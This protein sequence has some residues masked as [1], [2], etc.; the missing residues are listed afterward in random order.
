MS[1]PLTNAQPPPT[2]KD[3]LLTPGMLVKP[4]YRD[5]E[6]NLQVFLALYDTRHDM[7]GERCA[8]SDQD[9]AKYCNA[10]RSFEPFLKQDK[11]FSQEEDRVM[12]TLAGFDSKY[13]FEVAH[14]LLLSEKFEKEDLDRTTSILQNNIIK[15]RLLKHFD[16][17]KDQVKD[18]LTRFYK[19]NVGLH[20]DCIKLYFYDDKLDNEV[21]TETKEGQTPSSKIVGSH[22]NMY[23]FNSI[24]AY[25]DEASKDKDN[26]VIVQFKSDDPIKL[27]ADNQVPNLFM[28]GD[29]KMNISFNSAYPNGQEKLDSNTITITMAYTKDTD[30]TPTTEECTFT[31]DALQRQG[32]KLSVANLCNFLSV[33]G[34]VLDRKADISKAFNADIS[35][36]FNLIDSTDVLVKFGNFIIKFGG[37]IHHFANFVYNLKRSLDYS[38]ILLVKHF[39]NN[40]VDAL[41]QNDL[42]PITLKSASTAHTLITYD[43]LC[44]MKALMQNTPVIFQ[45]KRGA[46][47]ELFINRGNVQFQLDDLTILKNMAA[48]MNTILKT[49]KSTKILDIDKITDTS[50]IIKQLQNAHLEYM[51]LY[52]EFVPRMPINNELD[53]GISRINASVNIIAK[54]QI[55][56][57][58]DLTMK[59]IFDTIKDY[60]GYSEYAVIHSLFGRSNSLLNTLINNDLTK[61]RETSEKL[62]LLSE[63]VN[64]CVIV[65]HRQ[66]QESMSKLFDTFGMPYRQKHSEIPLNNV[67]MSALVALFKT[68]LIQVDK[69]TEHIENYLNGANIG[70]TTNAQTVISSIQQ[71]GF[72][73][74]QLYKWFD[75]PSN[76]RLSR[77]IIA[78][79]YAPASTDPKAKR[80]ANALRKALDNMATLKTEI[81]DGRPVQHITK[82]INAISKSFNQINSIRKSLQTLGTN[83]SKKN[84]VP[85][86]ALQSITVRVLSTLISEC[87][88]RL[89]HEEAIAESGIQKISN[90]SFL[91]RKLKEILSDDATYT[92]LLK[93]VYEKM[94]MDSYASVCYD[95]ISFLKSYD[96]GIQPYF[97]YEHENSKVNVYNNLKTISLG[98]INILELAVNSRVIYDIDKPNNPKNS[99]NKRQR[100]EPTTIPGSSKWP[101]SG[102]GKDDD[103]VG[104]QESV[105]F[106]GSFENAELH[107]QNLP[108]IIIDKLQIIIYKLQNDDEKKIETICSY[109]DTYIAD[110]EEELVYDD[111]VNL[112][113]CVL[114][115]AFAHFANHEVIQDVLP[116]ATLPVP[117]IEKVKMKGK[118]GHQFQPPSPS[119]Q[120]YISNSQH[121]SSPPYS[122]GSPSQP[123]SPPYAYSPASSSAYPPGSPA[124]SS[125]SRA[126]PPGS[127]AF[128]TDFPNGGN[129]S[130]SFFED[131]P[132]RN[133]RVKKP[134][135]GLANHL[136]AKIRKLV[137]EKVQQNNGGPKSFFTDAPKRNPIKKN[138]ILADHLSCKI[139]AQVLLKLQSE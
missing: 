18:I 74:D 9:H 27:N 56:K 86:P 110:N 50:V 62:I 55:A 133:P 129:I 44:F 13:D 14:E 90:I 60:L 52:G 40:T 70:G 135:A 115:I 137:L 108:R 28:P 111:F 4:E 33:V 87:T 51:Q 130:Y 77:V 41:V 94:L 63:L 48:V 98:L 125:A 42:E 106:E 16:K 49:I 68:D 75:Q 31:F 45:R 15:V 113:E 117:V 24:A 93:Y 8:I 17:Y 1:E 119:I 72:T 116:S 92:N 99:S 26:S 39:N 96:K 134:T 29:F 36:A 73:R 79:N 136:T 102:G 126:Y 67:K 101:R 82:S 19:K 121:P 124:S 53:I 104:S 105:D 131:K 127:P 84:N 69:L 66:S 46:H 38:Q 85:D 21:F 97:K 80:E 3:L 30:L 37:N 57:T 95:I 112:E 20:T 123:A 35:K 120:S 103:D 78:R 64:K 139:Q 7:L 12:E 107:I 100:E 47:Y 23:K 2:Q 61:L 71:R 132:K 122:Q 6:N 65:K 88:S 81:E 10:V 22:R 118:D 11:R 32:L 58:Q 76:Q 128:S 109:I 114:A 83:R 89:Q 91:K 138:S 25:W 34:N 5:L 54:T 59:V 43:R